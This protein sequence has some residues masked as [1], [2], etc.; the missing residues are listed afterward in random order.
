MRT[1]LTLFILAGVTLGCGAGRD[2]PVVAPAP[3]NDFVKSIILERINTANDSV[4]EWSD[5]IE[6]PVN[7]G[8]VAQFELVAEEAFPDEY[9]DR[10]VRHPNRWMIDVMTFP[11]GGKS[12]DKEALRGT[13]PIF[14]REPT[15]EKSANAD[16]PL[17]AFNSK[18]WYYCGFTPANMLKKPVSEKSRQRL[19][20]L[21]N[22]WFW[23][24][25]CGPKDQVGEFVYEIRIFPTAAWIS[26][27][28]SEFGDFVVI[29]RGLLRVV[30]A[31]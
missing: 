16:S 4:S 30:P 21:K 1:F 17:H 8:F 31:E 13:G 25:F 18:H 15:S 6:I 9:H 20:A 19:K 3:P 23:T 22:P 10:E 11:R 14:P 28:R 5:E 7:T 29:K 2:R 27:V 12:T 24:Y 26:P